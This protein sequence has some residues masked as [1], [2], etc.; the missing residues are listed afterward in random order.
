VPRTPQQAGRSRRSRRKRQPSRG[1]VLTESQRVL[2]Q[3]GAPAPVVAKREEATTSPQ[4]SP[5]LLQVVGDLKKSVT[6][7][8]VL[9]ILLVILSATL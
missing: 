5:Q 1:P 4:A 6:I 2:P 3:P 7:A 8:G 9:L